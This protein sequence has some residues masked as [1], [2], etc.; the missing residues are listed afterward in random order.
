MRVARDYFCPVCD[1][2]Y[3]VLIESTIDDILICEKCDSQMVYLLT[4]RG[5]I[6]TDSNLKK[7]FKNFVEETK[8]DYNPI[9]T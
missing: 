8:D 7:K 4:F 5:A 3:E 9:Q 2:Q 6:N 1:K